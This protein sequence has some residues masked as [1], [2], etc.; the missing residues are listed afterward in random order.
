VDNLSILQLLEGAEACVDAA[1]KA[2]IMLTPLG[3]AISITAFLYIQDK[4][5]IK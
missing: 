2:K 3:L 5:L 1:G 4:P